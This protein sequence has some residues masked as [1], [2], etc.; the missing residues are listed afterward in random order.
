MKVTS[1]DCGSDCVCKNE[2][3]SWKIEFYE[4][5]VKLDENKYLTKL[6]P[7]ELKQ[8]IENLLA[9]ERKKLANEFI[10]ELNFII[11]HN[12]TW[13]DVKGVCVQTKQAL[14]DKYIKD[15]E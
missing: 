9:E 15:S 4:K 3:M 8:Y 6:M 5:F 12:K 1:S 7:C 14:R 2:E 11:E 13:K 10:S